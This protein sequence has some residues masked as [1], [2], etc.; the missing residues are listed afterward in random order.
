MC[1]WIHVE[2]NSRQYDDTLSGASI[3]GDGQVIP[4]NDLWL[5]AS[6]VLLG[7]R[8]VET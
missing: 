8:L 3:E 2:S 7:M 4:Q 5:V 6:G 1:M